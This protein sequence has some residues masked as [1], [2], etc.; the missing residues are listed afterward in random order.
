MKYLKLVDDVGVGLFE[1]GMIKDDELD[2]CN[3]MSLFKV[4]GDDDYD[5]GMDLFRSASSI[6]EVLVFLDDDIDVMFVV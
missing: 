1:L 2:L 4:M 3:F 5:D 6:D